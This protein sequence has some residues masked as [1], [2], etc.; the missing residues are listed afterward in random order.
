MLLLPTFLPPPIASLLSPVLI[1]RPLACVVWYFG[2][3][4]FH[5]AYRTSVWFSS[6][7]LGTV[8][9]AL[10]A[11]SSL[12]VIVLS[13]RRTEFGFLLSLVPSVPVRL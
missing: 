6:I 11:R 10:S 9:S 4:F 5:R 3:P 2:A 8:Y 1:R 7:H 12:T 13:M